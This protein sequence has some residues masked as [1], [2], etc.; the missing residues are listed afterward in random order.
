MQSPRYLVGVLVELAPRVKHGHDDLGRRPSLFLMNVD[1]DPA[2]V[3]GNGYRLA[4]VNGNPDLGAVTGQ[5]LVDRV[6][7]RLKDHM[8]QT[9]AVI[10]ISDEHPRAFSYSL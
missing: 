8:V 7:D 9:G 6:V 4:F 10:G 5:R 1:R 3:V 2:T